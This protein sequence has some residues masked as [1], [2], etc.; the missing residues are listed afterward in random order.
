MKTLLYLHDHLSSRVFGEHQPSDISV[1]AFHVFFG[2][3]AL[4]TKINSSFA[5]CVQKECGWDGA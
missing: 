4:F 1:A 3:L 5:G 2:V